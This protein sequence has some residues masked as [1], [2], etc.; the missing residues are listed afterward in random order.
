MGWN[1]RM[2]LDPHALTLAVRWGHVVAMA[3]ALGGAVLV[4]AAVAARGTAPG[5]LAI[6]LA[7]ERVFWGAAG[8]LVMT[9]VGN[10]GAFGRSLPAPDTEW[11][12]A[13][14]VKLAAIALLLALSL[15]RTLAILEL[16]RRDA[17]EAPLR[18]GLGRLYGATAILL[19]LIVLVAQVLA[20]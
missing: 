15:P 10:L 14:T 16:G 17:A 2:A 20:H 1:G 13:L 5:A 18:R 12:A 11:G 8:V 19:G 4:T 7:Y 6:A 9:G 3:V